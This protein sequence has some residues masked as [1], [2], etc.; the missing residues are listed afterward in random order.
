MAFQ[1]YPFIIPPNKS[2]QGLADSIIDFLSKSENMETQLMIPDPEGNICVVQGR[3]LGGGYKQL[4]G[5]D[6]A[7][8]IRFNVMPGKKAVVVEIGEAKWIDK[9]VA[10]AAGLFVFA[11]LAVTSSI[12]MYQQKQ[13]QN[14]ILNA[15]Q[16]YLCA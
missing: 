16:Q 15:I 7:I 11:P 8:T 1:P 2:P 13:L 5:L 12:G 9:G 10:M 3:V 6:K 4:I 14:R